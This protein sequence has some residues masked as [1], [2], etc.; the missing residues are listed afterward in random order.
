MLWIPFERFIIK[1]MD[2]SIQAAVIFCVLIMVRVIFSLCKIPKKYSCFLWVIL[3]VRLILPIQIESPIGVLEKNS[4]TVSSVE[5]FVPSGLLTDSFQEMDAVIVPQTDAYIVTA[6]DSSNPGTE[7]WP[8]LTMIWGIGFAGF[9]LYGIISYGRLKKKLQCSIKS[10]DNC[11]LTDGI[12]TAFVIGFFSPQIYLPSDIAEED[13]FYVTLHEKTHIYRKDYLM[14]LAAYV[15]T[16]FYWF[17]PFVWAGLFFLSKDMEMA[18]DEAVMEKLGGDNR[19]VYADTLLRLSSGKYYFGGAPLAF[20]EGDTESRIRHI[21]KYKKPVIVAAAAAVCIISVLAAVL[22]TARPDS[23]TDSQTAGLGADMQDTV[24]KTDLQAPSRESAAGFSGPVANVSDLVVEI[25]GESYDIT[26]LCDSVNAITDVTEFG[27]YIVVEGH[28]NP[29]HSFY[30]FFDMDTQKWRYQYIGG[31]LTWDENWEQLD[32]PIESIIYTGQYT[33]NQDAVFNWKENV[34]AIVE[35][36]EGEYIRGLRRTGDDITISICTVEG[37]A[38]ELNFDCQSENMSDSSDTTN[39]FQ[40]ALEIKDGVFSP[41]EVDFFMSMEEVLQATGL[42]EYTVIEKDGGKLIRTNVNVF[43]F[44]NNITIDYGISDAV[45]SLLTGVGYVTV[46]D[47]AEAADIYNLL[48][49]QAVS[50]MPEA[51][52]NTIEGIKDGIDVSWEDKEQNYVRLTFDK[53]SSRDDN[54]II[55]H[56][57][58]EATRN[59]SFVPEELKSLYENSLLE[60]INR[61]MH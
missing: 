54:L 56:L 7:V 44:P 53:Y 21:M 38:R 20:G 46:V 25:D 40:Y 42:N 51:S 22:L 50:T 5:R 60:R 16:C 3:F 34:I 48:Y 39:L 8:I 41:R 28:I 37:G 59:A 32:N 1:M 29:S 23:E 6:S 31:C 9:L 43:G 55:I 49:E 47:E 58:I 2:I 4:V 61:E 12:S 19:A 26:E 13:M 36:K 15:T 10:E 35:L 27:D 18:C 14:K 33:S 17:H 52:G 11:Y 24:P 45:G 30:G 57:S